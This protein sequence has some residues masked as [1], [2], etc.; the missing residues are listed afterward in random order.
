MASKK[1]GAVAKQRTAKQQAALVEKQKR[2]EAEL[3]RASDKAAAQQLAQIV[4]LVIAGHSYAAIGAEIG[5]SADE[6]EKMLIDN[7]GQYI[8]TQPALRAY[9]R[10]FISEKYTGLLEATYPQAVDVNRADQLDYVS[11][12]QR[13]LKELG[14]LHGSEAPTQ[15]EVKIES[16]PEAVEDLV[17]RL[18]QSRGIDYDMDV[19]DAE[20]VEDVVGEVHEQDVRALEQASLDVEQEGDDDGL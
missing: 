1:K 20:V 8:R 10:N 4:N 12:V 5:K 7:A 14:R 3:L 9:V 18:A 17:T 6:I 15:S 16:T 13:T 11:A 2:D 19:F